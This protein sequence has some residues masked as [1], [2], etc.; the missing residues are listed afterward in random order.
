MHSLISLSRR[1][2]Y[3]EPT[4]LIPTRSCVCLHSKAWIPEIGPIDTAQPDDRRVRRRRIW[5][6]HLRRASQRALR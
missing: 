1:K 2:P 5:K 6:L 4:S 3:S